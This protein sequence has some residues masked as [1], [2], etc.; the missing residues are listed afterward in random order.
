VTRC[1]S[2]NN[3][4]NVINEPTYVWKINAYATYS[5]Y[6]YFWFLF[7]SLFSRDHF[8]LGWVPKVGSHKHFYTFLQ[9]SSAEK[10]K[11]PG[12]PGFK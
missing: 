2:H 5:N 11:I 3:K 8:R 9:L 4:T 10:H 12:I 1:F 7:N 6:Y